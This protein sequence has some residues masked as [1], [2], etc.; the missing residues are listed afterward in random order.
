MSDVAIVTIDA[1]I[2]AADHAA[3][4]W[5]AAE[6][7]GLLPGSERHKRAACQMFGETFNPY[8]PSVIAW[9]RLDPLA[10]AHRGSDRRQ[11]PVAHAGLR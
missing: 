4:H 3:R 6:S 9:P 7:G 11:G 5:R 8:K 2:A 1:R 10:L